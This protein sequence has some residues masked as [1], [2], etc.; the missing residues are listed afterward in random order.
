MTP[1]AARASYRR[2][3]DAHG[4]TVTLRRVNPSPTAPTDVT[5]RARVVGYQ[6]EEL[7]GAIQQGDRKIIALA[8]DVG[9]FPL[10]FRERFDKAI[11]RGTEMTIQAIDDNTRRVAGEL[12]A[13][14]IR[15]RG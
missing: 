14:D 15:V 7:V 1:E 4:E 5:V 6:P 9:A 8:E 2:Q 13:Y 3:I 12:I 11:I 10:P